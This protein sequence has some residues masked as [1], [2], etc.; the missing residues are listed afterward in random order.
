MVAGMVV[1]VLR[2][3]EPADDSQPLEV[4]RLLRMRT[5]WCIGTLYALSTWAD[6]LVFWCLDGAQVLGAIPHHPL[7][8]SCFYLGYATVVPALAVNLVH[9]ETAFY[10]QYRGYYAA[11]TGHASLDEIRRRGEGMRGALEHAAGSLLRVQGAFTAL[12]CWFAPEIVE[13][14]GLPEFAAR[15]LRLICIGALCHVLLLITVLI[16]LYFDRQRA[17]LR[18]VVAFLVGNVALAAWSVGAGPLTYGLGY[19]VAALVA[20]VWGLAEL[21]WTLGRLEHLTFVAR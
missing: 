17:A 4:G 7:Y 1:L 13:L 11:V 12:C 18:V 8:D 16:L 20:L 3:T 21:R 14:V 9:L 6:K 19:A 5:L 2:G 10:T 15:T